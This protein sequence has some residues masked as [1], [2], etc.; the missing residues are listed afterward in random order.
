[1]ILSMIKILF[2]KQFYFIHLQT[3][4]TQFHVVGLKCGSCGSY[5]T[6]RSGNEEIPGESAEEDEE[7]D[8]EE[9]SDGGYGYNEDDRVRLA[10][11]RQRLGSIIRQWEQPTEGEE[12]N[13]DDIDSERNRQQQQN[14]FHS[15]V[16]QLQLF[17]GMLDDFSGR[18]D[19]TESEDTESEDFSE[20]S[21]SHSEGSDED[22]DNE[23]DRNEESDVAIVDSNSDD[24]PDAD[25][26]D[27]SSNPSSPP[28]SYFSQP[29]PIN[30]NEIY[31]SGDCE[32]NGE[33]ADSNS[34]WETE[35][36]EEVIGEVG[37]NTSNNVYN[38]QRQIND[39]TGLSGSLGSVTLECQSGVC[40]CVCV[41][42]RACVC[43]YMAMLAALILYRY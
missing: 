34:S 22:D 41:C 30:L 17:Q 24:D 29:H 7:E 43:V 36:E 40:V 19:D 11:L 18:Y 32:S 8:I 20:Q 25:D 12:N 10:L 38:V 23:D 21:S 9:E 1:M 15:F 14:M 28:Y 3:T 27:D 33:A 37:G 35:E 26:E 6:S 2:Y 31:D 4:T 39:I 13:G 42:V 16:N 5:N